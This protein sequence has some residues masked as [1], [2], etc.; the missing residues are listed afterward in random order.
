MSDSINKL[1]KMQTLCDELAAVE[2]ERCNGNTGYS[3]GEVAA[4]M[5]KEINLVNLDLPYDD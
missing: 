1:E 5:R 3:V 4:M 2:A